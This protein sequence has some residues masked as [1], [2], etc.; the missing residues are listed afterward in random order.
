MPGLAAR[1]QAGRQT[2]RA[3]R[4]APR[5]GPGRRPSFY[6]GQFS[7]LGTTMGSPRDLAALPAF[8]VEYGVAPQV[9]DRTFP[10][11]DAAAAH[12][13]LEGGTGF[14]KVVLLR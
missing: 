10:L 3:R 7:L 13:H 8:L 6:F 14:G 11:A 5:A 2:D 4:V 1:A 9:L 12:E